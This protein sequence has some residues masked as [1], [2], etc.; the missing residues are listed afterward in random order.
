MCV[1]P[2]TDVSTRDWLLQVWSAELS[3]LIANAMLAQRVSSINT[4]AQICEATGADVGEVSRIVGMD[5]RIGPKFLNPSIGFGGSCFQKDILNL[6][7]ICTSKGLDDVAEYWSQVI[8]VNDMQRTRFAQKVISS[9]FNTVSG[10]KICMFG[11]AFKK[12]TADTR[13]TSS[14][15]PHSTTL[16]LRLALTMCKHSISHVKTCR[17]IARELLD[18]RCELCVH[19]PQVTSKHS[20]GTD[21][22]MIVWCNVGLRGVGPQGDS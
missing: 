9:M 19:D 10:K 1:A 2:L 15:Y 18:E 8:K 3:K 7:Y 21:P 5:T 6:I 12:D 13:E 4:V 22:L 11:F 16:S 14:M 17:Y 20:Y